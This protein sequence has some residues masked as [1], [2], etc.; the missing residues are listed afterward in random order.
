VDTGV[1]PAALVGAAPFVA[2]QG[3]GG[4]FFRPSVRIAFLRTASGMLD[5]PGGKAAFTWTVGRLDACP[6]AGSIGPIAFEPCARL[7]AGVLEA[8]G[9]D[10]VDAL[11]ESRPWLALG[12]VGRATWSF[13]RAVFVDADLGLLVRPGADRFVFLPDITVY[14]VPVVAL[15]VALGLGMHFF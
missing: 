5:V 3:R 12:P 15:S 8:A 6:I 4:S 1:S 2:W 10:V 9:A 7:E 14:Q 13:S 11:T